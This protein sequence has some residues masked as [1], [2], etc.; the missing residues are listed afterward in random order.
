MG[1]GVKAKSKATEQAMEIKEMMFNYDNPCDEQPQVTANDIIDYVEEKFK[2]EQHMSNGTPYRNGI[3]IAFAQLSMFIQLIWNILRK[4]SRVDQLFDWMEA[5]KYVVSDSIAVMATTAGWGVLSGL[6]SIRAA[7]RFAEKSREKWEKLKMAVL[8][9]SPELE[10]CPSLLRAYVRCKNQ[11]GDVMKSTWV[12]KCL[13]IPKVLNFMLII[14]WLRIYWANWITYQSMPHPISGKILDKLQYFTQW[15]K[16][17]WS[18]SEIDYVMQCYREGWFMNGAATFLQFLRDNQ[19]TENATDK[20]IGSFTK[21]VLFNAGLAHLPANIRDM[22]NVV[23]YSL[24]VLA[25]RIQQHISVALEHHLQILDYV[26]ANGIADQIATSKH[27]GLIM[28]KVYYMTRSR[29]FGIQNLPEPSLPAVHNAVKRTAFDYT[30]FVGHGVEPA[31]FGLKT[32]D[33]RKW[34]LSML[35]AQEKSEEKIGDLVADEIKLFMSLRSQLLGDIRDAFGVHTCVLKDGAQQRSD[36]GLKPKPGYHVVVDCPNPQDKVYYLHKDKG[37]VIS[38]M[39]LEEEQKSLLRDKLKSVQKQRDTVAD[40]AK[41]LHETGVKALKKAHKESPKVLQ[42]NYS[43]TDL[44][45]QLDK[46]VPAKE[47]EYEKQREER[48]KALEE[49]LA[50]IRKEMA[51]A[52]LAKDAHTHAMVKVTG[53]D[54]D[55]FPDGLPVPLAFLKIDVEHYFKSLTVTPLVDDNPQTFKAKCANVIPIELPGLITVFEEEQGKGN[56]FKFK[57]KKMTHVLIRWKAPAGNDDKDYEI[58]VLEKDCC[59][60]KW[61]YNIRVKCV[62]PLI[63]K[64]KDGA[65]ASPS[66]AKPKAKAKPLTGAAKRKAEA[67]AELAQQGK[68]AMEKSKSSMKGGPPMKMAKRRP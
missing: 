51:A 9:L 43:K 22:Y 60:G 28:Q 50:S 34:T 5:G 55:A 52:Q 57:D 37:R 31:D 39:R 40:E 65:P 47:K 44:Q 64:K 13:E 32:K 63:K 49:K 6:H 41:K 62:G 67:M 38:T 18:T 61:K 68:E 16:G 35:T 17:I 29:L 8:V 56:V 7:Q 3:L 26:K 46:E 48:D 20:L 45:D 1:T 15:I 10:K 4:A 27:S 25:P 2:S 19:D 42:K 58:F 54:G 14:I 23:M 11:I 24:V 33:C 59:I 12:E 21:A 30:K 66:R 36:A 53:P